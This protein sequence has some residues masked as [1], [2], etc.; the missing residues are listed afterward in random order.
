MIDSNFKNYKNFC[1]FFNLKENNANSLQ[2]YY[3]FKNLVKVV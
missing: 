2:K 3:E 1:E